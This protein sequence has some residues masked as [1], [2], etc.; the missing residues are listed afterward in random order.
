[1]LGTAKVPVVMQMEAVECGAAS[2]CMILAYYGKWLPLEQVRSDCGVS[3]DGASAK[4]IVRAARMYGLK[5]EGYR[6]EPEALKEITLP[7]IIHWNFNHFVVLDRFKKDKVVLNDPARGLVEVSYEEFDKAFTG[8]VLKFE[9]TNEFVPEGKQKSVLEFAKKRL[10]GTLPQFIFILLTGILI[11]VVGVITPLY[12]KIFMDNIL[13]D[14]NPEWFLPLIAAMIITWIFSF[15]V[16]AIEDICWIKMEGKF[17]VVA[18][19]EFMWHVLRLPIDFFSQRYVGDIASRQYSNEAIAGSMIRQLAPVFMNVSL[20]VFY[21]AIMT[22]YSLLLT[23]IGAS[24]AIINLF[25][26]RYSSKK[27]MNFSRAAMRDGGKLAAATMSGIEMIESIKASGAE[28]GFFERWAGYYAKQ[29]N[30]KAQIANYSAYIGA[31]PAILQQCSNILVLMAGVYMILDGKFTIGMI[32]AFQSFLGSFMAPVNQLLSVNQSFI[33]MRSSMERVEDVMNY[34]TDGFETAGSNEDKL[35]SE[36][37]DAAG[38]LSGAV[39]IKKISFGY[40]KLE[41]PLIQDF[42][43]SIKPGSTVAFVGGSGS[44]KSTLAKLITGLYPV[45]EGEILFDG[46]KKEQIDEYTYKSSVSMVD[47][48]ITIFEDTVANN[49][50]MWDNSIEDFAVIMAARDADIHETIVSRPG[51]YSHQI[52]ED[53]KNFSGGQRQRLEIARVLAEEPTIIILDEATSALDAKTEEQVMRNIRNIGATC[54]II[55]HRLSTIRDCDEIVVLKN[56]VVEERGT[57][58]VLYEKNGLYTELVCSE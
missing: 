51:G 35:A 6:M 23:I 42:S 28:Q 38:K 8:I 2:L 20:L 15:L 14:K 44:G 49:I 54:I 26:M 10:K 55:A 50:R 12:S 58:E 16:S 48:D 22:N 41:K 25:F 46:K 37:A 53:G 33:M 17:A 4:N 39:E 47:Q 43:I 30:A 7:A 29:Q 9:K 56:G 34:K 5:A 27:Q 32:I 3:R 18:N 57:H 21:L 1:M 45:W 24:T 13:S 19:A 52:M 31:I 40:S 11:S 36:K